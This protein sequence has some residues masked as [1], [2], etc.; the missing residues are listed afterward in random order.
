MT[1]YCRKC[2]TS[3][4]GD[5]IRGLCPQCY[6]EEEDLKRRER[7]RER[8]REYEAERRHREILEQ[9]ELHHQEMLDA[10]LP[11]VYCEHCG[12][13]MRRDKIGCTTVNSGFL[14]PQCLKKEDKC[15]DCNN[16]YVVDNVIIRYERDENFHKRSEEV[17]YTEKI[18]LPASDDSHLH[19]HD[20]KIAY[21]Q[22]DDIQC[23]HYYLCPDCER[24]SRENER[25]LWEESKKLEIEYNRLKSTKER[26]DREKKERQEKNEKE[27]QKNTLQTFS[28]ICFGLVLL[29]ACLVIGYMSDQMTAAAIVGILLCVV[30]YLLRSITSSLFMGLIYGIGIGLAFGLPIAI[31]S[32]F[33]W[34]TFLMPLIIVALVGMVVGTILDK[35]GVFDSKS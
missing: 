6:N 26:Q 14:C 9:E 7:E 1:K 35:M 15:S 27:R 21:T 24:Q 20:G 32:W 10:T 2:F 3:L 33:V 18:W 34:D 28:G 16:W 22:Y 8:E 5:G 4:Y 12:E 11:W 19:K 31:V 13:R 29:V 25:G 30:S 23:W 17:E